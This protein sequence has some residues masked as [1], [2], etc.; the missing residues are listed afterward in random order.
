MFSSFGKISTVVEILNRGSNPTGCENAK[1]TG[2][3]SIPPPPTSPP[4]TNPPT[5]AKP[6]TEFINCEKSL[7]CR[8]RAVNT[9]YLRRPDW[10]ELLSDCL[11]VVSNFE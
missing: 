9:I 2:S 1:F 11:I 10:M 3:G 8:W 6:G 7:N 4:S 5:G